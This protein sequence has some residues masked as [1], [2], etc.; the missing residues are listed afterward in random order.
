MREIEMLQLE[1]DDSVPLSEGIMR[2]PSMNSRDIGSFQ[3][4]PGSFQS[5][6]GLAHSTA[7]GSRQLLHQPDVDHSGQSLSQ[8]LANHA[9]GADVNGS[10]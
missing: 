3:S 7:G 6:P 2:S 9:P 1:E 10:N 8:A 4:I 5:V